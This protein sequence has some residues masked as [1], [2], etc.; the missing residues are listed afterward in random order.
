MVKSHP[1]RVVRKK[2]GRPNPASSEE[3]IHLFMAMDLYR[4]KL[5]NSAS[6]EQTIHPFMDANLC[7]GLIKLLN[8]PSGAASLSTGPSQYPFLDATLYREVVKSHLASRCSVLV[9]QAVVLEAV[10][11]PVDSHHLMVKEREGSPPQNSGKPFGIC[12][13]AHLTRICQKALARLTCWAQMCSS[14]PR[15]CSP[16][17]T[18]FVP[19]ANR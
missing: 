7:H 13:S 10:H 4:P 16:K 17:R 12:T 6:S 2:K 9:N 15:G 18:V 11:P 3:R 19:R 14:P 8:P 1:R 5:S